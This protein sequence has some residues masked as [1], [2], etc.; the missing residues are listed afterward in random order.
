MNFIKDI[1]RGIMIGIANIIPGVS[2]GTMM[3]SM[4]I[5]DK[6]IGAINQIFRKLKESI[7]TLFPYLI[8]MIIGIVGLSF[9]IE[10]FFDKYPLQT[11]LLFIGLIF[12]GLPVILKRMKGKKVSLA[13]A[14]LFVVFFALVILLQVYGGDHGAERVLEVNAGQL[15]LMVIVGIIAS[16][17]MV[18]PGV[19][20]S[21]ILMALGYYSPIISEINFFIKALLALETDGLLH[22]FAIL[23]PFGIGVIL[24]IIGIAKLIEFLLK[25]YEGYTYCAILGLVFA[26]PVA[27]LMGIGISSI[28]VLGVIVS[29]ITFAVGFITA[30]FLSK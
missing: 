2:G 14:G 25:K 6:I 18:I 24:G 10:F 28:S 1:L 19:S 3:V 21:M 27:V 15:L 22:G 5:Y 8:G 7:K 17:T 11:A 13:G 29:L 26:S 4:G 23:L 16:A 9:C 20:G 12:G 30:L